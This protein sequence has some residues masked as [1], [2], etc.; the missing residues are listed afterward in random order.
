MDLNTKLERLEGIA[1]Y[2]NGTRTACEETETDFTT[3][4]AR[5]AIKRLQEFLTDSMIG[6]KE[7]KA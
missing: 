7:G 1:D 3:E 6:L 2:L 5:M 4:A